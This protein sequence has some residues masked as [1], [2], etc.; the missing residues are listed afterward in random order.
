M[1]IQRVLS[2][3]A[4]LVLVSCDVQGVLVLNNKTD[5]PAYYRVKVKDTITPVGVRARG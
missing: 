3:I 2:I 5:K 1:S 4:A